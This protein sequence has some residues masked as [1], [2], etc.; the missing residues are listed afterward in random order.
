MSERTEASR[1]DRLADGYGGGLESLGGGTA[2]GRGGLEWCGE[3]ERE[4]GMVW[5][6]S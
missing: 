2:V 3:V 6:G 4:V 5:R 1:A